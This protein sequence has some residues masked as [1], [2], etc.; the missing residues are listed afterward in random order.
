M[1]V[2]NHNSYNLMFFF[3]FS[4]LKKNK[5]F[6]LLKSRLDYVFK[7]EEDYSILE[8]FLGY[9]L[10]GEKYEPIFPYYSHVSILT[11][12]LLFKKKY[13][14]ERNYNNRFDFMY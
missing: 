11:F 7:S 8:E 5:L 14:L 10:K 6:I 2:K 1:H 12:F 4:D 3:V 13:I 9:Q